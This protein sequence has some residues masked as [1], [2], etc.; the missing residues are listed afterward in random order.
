MIFEKLKSLQK[1][2]YEGNAKKGFW[3]DGPNRNKAEACMLMITELSEA[4]EGHRKGKMFDMTK[5]G[6]FVGHSLITGDEGIDEWKKDFEHSVKDTV[7]DEIADTVIRLLDTTYGFEWPLV[8]RDYRKVSTGNFSHDVFRLTHYCLEAYHREV[9]EN[10][11]KDW[12]HF[13]SAIIKFCEWYN[14]DIVQH[15]EWKLK[16]N[17][18]RPPKHGKAY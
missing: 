13:L 1:S 3:D 12:G 17:A 7:A 8:E 11:S 9:E 14:I 5:I 10:G 2:I 18:T 4:V 15:V 6:S 16:Y